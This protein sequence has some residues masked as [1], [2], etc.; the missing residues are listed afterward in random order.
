MNE[1]DQRTIY[2]A[3]VLLGLLVRGSTVASIPESTKWIV[4][5]VIKSEGV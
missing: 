2:T 4:D 5:E 1:Q 3:F